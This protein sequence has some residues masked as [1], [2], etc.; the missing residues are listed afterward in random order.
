MENMNEILKNQDAQFMLL[1]GFII[2]IGLVITTIILNS[3]IFEVNI[4]IGGGNELSKNDMINL[5][6]IT[7][8]EFRRAYN[9]SGS[10]ANFNTTLNNFNGNLSKLYALHGE[11]V[12]LIS[13][14]VSN[15]SNNLNASFTDNGLSG[16]KTNWTLVENVNNSNITIYVSSVTPTF[17]INIS[18]ATKYWNINFTTPGE[19]RTIN[20]TQ[21]RKNITSPYSISFINGSNAN[22]KFRINGT[23]TNGKN[24]I[25]AHDY[26]L[27]CT[28]SFSMSRVR[29]NITIPITVPW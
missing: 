12:K 9:S 20:I 1:A 13:W 8:D 21:I 28:I 5:M 16:G 7:K 10:T 2:A 29:T 11:A 3:I 22:G 18:N 6:Q 25:R 19:N 23:I 15:W 17:I 4:A 14:D 26:V 27:S 24:F